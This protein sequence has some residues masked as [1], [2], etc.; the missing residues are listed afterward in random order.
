[1]KKE[2]RKRELDKM[3]KELTD[4]VKRQEAQRRTRVSNMLSNKK[5]DTGLC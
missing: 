1:M 3:Y 2:T 4:P 5:A